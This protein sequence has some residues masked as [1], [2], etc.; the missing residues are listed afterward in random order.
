MKG[1]HFTLQGKRQFRKN[2]YTLYSQSGYSLLE[3]II[4]ILLISVLALILLIGF[5]TAFKAVVT[6][7][8]QYQAE[9]LARSQID[10]VKQQDYIDYSQPS[11]G[12]YS[13][14]N[15]PVGY[16]I[17]IMVTPIDSST[18][19]EL[20]SGDNGIQKIIIT[21]VFNNDVIKS[22]EGYKVRRLPGS[23]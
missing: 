10:S 16:N 3:S 17:V 5:S 8:R 19:Q 9:T 21:V 22:L 20:I 15:A 13:L 12:F 6:I 11:H 7:N 2:N 1:I 23:V 4:A 14:I 18:G